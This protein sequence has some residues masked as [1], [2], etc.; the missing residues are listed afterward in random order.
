[1]CFK[2]RSDGFSR[3]QALTV[4]VARRVVTEADGPK[5]PLLTTSDQIRV[6]DG[7]ER[8]IKKIIKKSFMGD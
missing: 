8:L 5:K 1:M 6:C 7:K 3:T 4:Y 2:F